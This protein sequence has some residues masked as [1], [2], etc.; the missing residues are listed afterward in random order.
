[1]IQLIMLF[2]FILG[3]NGKYQEKKILD[4][5]IYPE[6]KKIELAIEKNM[7]GSLAE[8]LFIKIK[9]TKND[10]GVFRFTEDYLKSGEYEVEIALQNIKD[11]RY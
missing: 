8:I 1:M 5:I 9:D 2:R 3:R 10:L 4:A 6:N 7:V 11:K